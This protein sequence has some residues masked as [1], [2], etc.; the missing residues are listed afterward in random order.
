ML[1]TS[2]SKDL[3]QTFLRP[4]AEDRELM[5]VARVTAVACSSVGALI[6]ILLPTVISALTIFY[7][8]LTAAL[9]LPLVAGLYTA[10]VTARAAMATM[11]ASVAITFALEII[12][13]ATEGWGLPPAVFALL[14]S[15]REMWEATA[16]RWG[17]PPSIW[18]M[19]AGAAVMLAA[20]AA[21]RPNES[22]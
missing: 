11:L 22:R 21:A 6:A 12:T 10:R 17:I 5:I 1:S 4:R 8:L 15:W 13:Q 7:T 14:R 19:A 2:L 16:G 20:S 9:L 18:G 3:Y